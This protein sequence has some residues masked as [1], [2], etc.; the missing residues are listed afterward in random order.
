VV[1]VHFTSHAA[2]C[3]LD[4][5]VT[6]KDVQLAT[7]LKSSTLPSHLQRVPGTQGKETKKEELFMAVIAQGRGTL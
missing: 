1:G 4:R 7:P 6:D 5:R 2:C 3:F